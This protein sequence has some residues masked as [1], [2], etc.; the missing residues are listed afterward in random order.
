M[1]CLTNRLDVLSI[2]ESRTLGD[3]VPICA[4]CRRIRDVEGFWKR[5]EAY[6]A[7]HIKGQFSH[8]ICPDCRKR[9]YAEFAKN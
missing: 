5:V 4:N 2:A 7:I 8:S 6:V 1:E 9:L 3:I